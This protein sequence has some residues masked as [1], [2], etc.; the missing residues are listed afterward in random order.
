MRSVC[1][2]GIWHPVSGILLLSRPQFQQYIGAAQTP[3]QM[4][5]SKKPAT[6]RV[7]Q[8]AGIAVAVIG[9]AFAV[10]PHTLAAICRCAIGRE[11]VA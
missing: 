9:L 2:S 6:V 8:F 5:P 11:K 3:P 7:A 10:Q 4:T 1:S